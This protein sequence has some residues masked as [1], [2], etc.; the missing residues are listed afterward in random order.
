VTEI[1][2]YGQPLPPDSQAKAQLNVRISADLAKELKVE[3]A[4]VGLQIGRYVEL[5]LVRR[6]ELLK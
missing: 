6:T 1:N 5:I 4:Q 2:V 3:A